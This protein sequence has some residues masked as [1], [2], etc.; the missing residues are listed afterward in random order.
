MIS[1]IQ[2]QFSTYFS[3]APLLVRAPGRINLIGE[4]TDYNKGLVFPAAINRE[5]QFA[6]AASGDADQCS[7]VALDLNEQYNFRLSE[8]APLSPNSWQNYIMGVVHELRA[9]GYKPAGFNLVFTSNIP[10]G[11]GL[12]SSAALECGTCFGLNR[13][14]SLGL[15]KMKRVKIS[16]RAEHHY[17]GVQCGI[18]DQFAS[19]MGVANRAMLLDC[20]TLDYNYFPLDLQ[21]YSL[22][23]CDSGVK[24]EL[25][26]SEYNQRRLECREGVDILSRTFPDI[27]SLR[28]AS[29]EQLNTV[30]HAMPETIYRRCQYVLEENRRVTQFAAALEAGNLLMAGNLMK[31]AQ[32]GM[33]EK[34]EIT[35]PE[36]NFMANFA[37]AYQDVAGSRMMGGGFGGCTLNLVRKGKEEAFITALNQQYA[38]EFTRHIAPFPVAIANG[39]TELN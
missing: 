30:K 32:K 10:P 38:R 5:M 16:Q 1:T 27:A 20:K 33:R 7:V 35:C 8:L 9:A 17:T 2:Q 21:R 29:V 22:V 3:G 6:M 31:A 19:T 34:Y 26:H 36:I 18:M 28:D 24:H 23:L 11:A 4:H 14:F 13:L 25:A 15:D 37:N 12:S 39:V